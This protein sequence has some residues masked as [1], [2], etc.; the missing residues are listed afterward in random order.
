MAKIDAAQKLDNFINM[1]S[2]ISDYKKQHDR[3]PTTAE[4]VEKLGMSRATVVRYKGVIL[5]EN[6]KTILD[7]F[8]VDIIKDVEDLDKVMRDNAKF[9]KKIRDGEL[10]ETS[11]Q[12]NAARNLQEVYLDLIRIKRD[13]PE[14]LGIDYN[15]VQSEQEHIHEQEQGFKVEQGISSLFD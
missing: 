1:R 8:Q 7:T 3:Y 12:M 2:M 13:A 9:F 6:K 11:D 14:F 15:N 5:D 4:I 10:N